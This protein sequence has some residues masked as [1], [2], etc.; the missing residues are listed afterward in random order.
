MVISK[1]VMFSSHA[2]SDAPPANEDVDA[3]VVSATFASDLMDTCVSWPASPHGVEGDT[4]FDFAR[5]YVER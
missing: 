3:M 1:R 2:K 4:D 5:W